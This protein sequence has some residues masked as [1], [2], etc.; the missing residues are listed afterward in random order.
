MVP[1]WN[2]RKAELHSREFRMPCV[3]KAIYEHI[4]YLEDESTLSDGYLV[5]TKEEI[6]SVRCET[7]KILLKTENDT[8][9]NVYLYRV[10]QKKETDAHGYRNAVLTNHRRNNFSAR[11]LNQAG[12][13]IQTPMEL[14]RKIEELSESTGIKA[15]RFEIVDEIGENTF[16]GDMNHFADVRVFPNDKRKVLLFY[17]K[18]DDYPEDYLLKAHVRYVLSQLQI[19]FMEYR[20]M[21]IFI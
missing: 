21:G 5:E 1:L 8:M 4:F 16:C 18:G 6:L 7:D 9:D 3:D 14:T 19:E 2:I 20:C 13:F 10:C 17:F 11:Y 12:N 15:V